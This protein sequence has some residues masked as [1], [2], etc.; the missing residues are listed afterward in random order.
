MNLEEVYEALP[1]INAPGESY[2]TIEIDDSSLWRIAKDQSDHP[3]VIFFLSS[4]L[5]S[6]SL[7]IELRNISYSPCKVVEICIEESRRRETVAILK[8][9]SGDLVLRRYF[10]TVLTPMLAQ[11]NDSTNEAQIGALIAKTIE[12]FQALDVP[13]R[14]SLQGLWC[15]LMLI[16]QSKNAQQAIRAWH[17][18]PRSLYDFTVGQHSIEVKSSARAL[19]SH[20]FSLAPTDPARR[21][22]CIHR[23]YSA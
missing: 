23:F 15:E 8:C 6:D 7:P 12:L 13:A 2:S 11:L 17:P 5:P 10:L 18:S 9:T 19:R 14:S 1:A 22:L 16:A 21:F 3:A 20:E 4:S